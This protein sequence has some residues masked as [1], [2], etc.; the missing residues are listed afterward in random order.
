MLRQ[1]ARAR[2]KRC[3][4]TVRHRTPPYATVRH[5]APLY[6]TVRHCRGGY[7]VR[8][9]TPPYAKQATWPVNQTPTHVMV[10]QLLRVNARGVVAVV[11]VVVPRLAL[12]GARG[13]KRG[14][15]SATPCAS[16]LHV[17]PL[18]QPHD[19]STPMRQPPTHQRLPPRPLPTRAHPTCV[20]RTTCGLW[21]H[22]THPKRLEVG[23]PVVGFGADAAGR[24]DAATV[25][26][27][28]GGRC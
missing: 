22:A 23:R 12:Q 5:C 2:R 4:A 8:H 6:A 7:G 16:T 1:H 18:H 3:G 14:G 9:R 10:A 15:S 19:E 25:T 27:C 24:G 28:G 13:V 26:T 21:R 20:V 11:A 17:N